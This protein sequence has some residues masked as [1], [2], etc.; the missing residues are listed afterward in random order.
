MFICEGTFVV[1]VHPVRIIITAVITILIIATTAIIYLCAKYYIYKWPFKRL[2]GVVVV[3]VA[4]LLEYLLTNVPNR[5]WSIAIELI[6]LGMW[7]SS[8]FLYLQFI[9]HILRGF[10]DN[11]MWWKIL[12]YLDNYKFLAI[13]DKFQNKQVRKDYMATQ[14]K[15]LLE[16]KDFV[17]KLNISVKTLD[18]AGRL[19][20]KNS[21]NL[22]KGI[23]NLILWHIFIKI[24][25]W[26]KLCFT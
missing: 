17:Y 22:N 11:E 18:I 21:C 2:V 23:T 13:D 1:C 14:K 5:L 25:W 24:S 4:T 26:K 15:R 12:R 16:F 3:V 19:K 7:H 6:P 9:S 10:R 8:V 20:N